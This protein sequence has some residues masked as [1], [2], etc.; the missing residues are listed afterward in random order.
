[1]PEISCFEANFPQNFL[2]L[3]PKVQTLYYSGNALLFNSARSL[4]IVGSRKMTNYGREVI[5]RIVPPLVEAGLTLIS[6]FMYGVDQEVHRVCLECGGQ[7]VAVLGWGIDWSEGAE[8]QELQRKLVERGL[9]VS[10]YPQKTVPQLWMFPARDRLMAALGQG[11]LV[12]EA[13]RR[14]GS[15]IT[16]D[17]A[18][19]LKRP[20][21][22]V[23]GPITSV[24]SAGTN[25]LLQRGRAVLIT[26]ANEILTV[27]GYSGGQTA[28]CASPQKLPLLLEYL[29]RESLTVEELV[30][31]T[32][33]KAEEIR[34]KLMVAELRGE[35]SEENG[36]YFLKN[37]N[38]N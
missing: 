1:M 17:Y 38:Q 34:A 35:V 15:L 14:S 21:F 7:T 26:Q 20:L 16:A 29:S 6:G 22:A 3:K 13:A 10:Q 12:I 36:K 27:L 31:K 23:P 2:E 30:Q 9:L 5:N 11:T 28:P 32:R 24:V 25:E 8:N 33:L 4:T 19:K 37:V 18:G